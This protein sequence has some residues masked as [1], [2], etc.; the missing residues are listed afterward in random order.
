MSDDQRLA[1]AIEAFMAK[2]IL[3]LC[4]MRGH[5]SKAHLQ[6]CACAH[7]R[8]MDAQATITVDASTE[9]SLRHVAMIA[10]M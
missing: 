1:A 3:V 4:T 9:C 8:I 6:L 5:I 2:G 7:Y 10:Q